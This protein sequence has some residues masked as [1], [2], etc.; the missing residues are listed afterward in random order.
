MY[1]FYVLYMPIPL[2]LFS[3]Y[4]CVMDCCAWNL[5]YFNWTWT[6]HLVLK[7]VV[8]CR[9]FWLCLSLRLS[10][11]CLWA[12]MP[13]IKDTYLLI[14]LQCWLVVCCFAMISLFDYNQLFGQVFSALKSGQLHIPYRNSKLTHILQP[15]LGGDAKVCTVYTLISF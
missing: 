2:C 14:D 7:T 5:L 13:E 15:S 1:V 6:L 12:E 8:V 9:C 3:L 10:A 11:C 4:V